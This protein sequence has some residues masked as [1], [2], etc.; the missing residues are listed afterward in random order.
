[1]SQAHDNIRAEIE[2]LE[3]QLS[4][5]LDNRRL[6]AQI[7]KRIDALMAQLA[8]SGGF[9]ASNPRSLWKQRKVTSVPAIMRDLRRSHD[10]IFRQVQDALVGVGL[11]ESALAKVGGASGPR[12]DLRD[13][14][15]LY[16]DI[17]NSGAL[18]AAG[19]KLEHLSKLA[20][21]R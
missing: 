5:N 16:G 3:E 21:F 19:E 10:D 15:D 9:F 17:L 18:R 12:N 1:M 11:L 6:A 7:R 8:G 20:G 14:A 4:E 13:I 2:R